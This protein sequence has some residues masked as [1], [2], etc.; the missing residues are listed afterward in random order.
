MNRHARNA[1]FAAVI[2][3]IGIIAFLHA[4]YELT[5]GTRLEHWQADRAY[6][7]GLF[8][9]DWDFD[10]KHWPGMPK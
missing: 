10:L 8:P 4:A 7:S 3:G 2:T 9:R 6:D 1:G 5:I